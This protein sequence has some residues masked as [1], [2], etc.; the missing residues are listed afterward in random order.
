MARSPTWRPGLTVAALLMAWAPTV[1]SQSAATLPCVLE[2]GPT[3][4]VAAVI[5]GATV[6]LDDGIEL[7]LLDVLGP[8][9]DDAGAAGASAWPPADEARAELA[10]LIE[11]Q[12]IALAF[13]GERADRYGRVLAHA[14]VKREADDVWVQG[15]LVE[16]GH[17][18]VAGARGAG[19]CLAALLDRERRARTAQAGIWAHAG[20]Q[21]R[22]GDRPEELARYRHTF[23]LVRG[24]VERVRT[25]RTL[26]VLELTS[27]TRAPRGS[28]GRQWGA[29]R[30][31]WKRSAGLPAG[32]E[33]ADQ[34]AGRNVLARGWVEV[35]PGRGPEI[36]IVQLAELDFE[37]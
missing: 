1:R 3:R 12:S 7:R 5:D 35:A 16:R 14:F 31:T 21:V 29:L 28:D 36:E 27:S 25:T 15:A 10:A 18:R 20:Y 13:A 17:A 19:G 6:R 9:A 26:M 22:P 23:Q 33:R 11:G 30:L 32:V 24:R 8:H 34:L 2:P 37:D 4:A